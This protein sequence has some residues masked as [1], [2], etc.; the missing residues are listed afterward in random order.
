M[1]I[2]PRHPS[3]STRAI[4]RPD[5]RVRSVRR[6]ANVANQ[7][8]TQTVYHLLT[9]SHILIQDLSSMNELLPVLPYLVGVVEHFLLDHDHDELP[10]VIA[11]AVH[12]VDIL[13]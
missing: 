13:K 10:H 3:L 7:G 1:L 11:L 8:I 12:V 4:E 6:Y 2:N 5:I 9:L